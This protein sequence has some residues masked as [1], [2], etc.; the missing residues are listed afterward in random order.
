MLKIGGMACEES[1]AGKK[2]C[3]YLQKA[4]TITA[5]KTSNEVCN[6]DHIC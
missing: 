5:V 1:A 4:C 3:I 6:K 2:K